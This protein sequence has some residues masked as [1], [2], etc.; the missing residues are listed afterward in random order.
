MKRLNCI[1]IANADK[2]S[3]QTYVSD[4]LT[5]ICPDAK[6]LFFVLYT[7]LSKSLS[8]M[9]LKIQPAL[10]IKTEPKKIA[11]SN[12]K[13]SLSSDLKNR[14]MLSPKSKAKIKA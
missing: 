4:L 10:L 11:L 8:T 2:Q 12:L 7:F 3:K 13:I 5:E 6:G 14:R 1:K 9:S